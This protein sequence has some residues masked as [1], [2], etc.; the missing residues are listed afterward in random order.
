MLKEYSRSVTH[1]PEYNIWFR[2]L[3]ILFKESCFCI[4]KVRG[5]PFADKWVS[6]STSQYHKRELFFFLEWNPKGFMGKKP[7]LNRH[8]RAWVREN[9][10]ERE[11]ERDMCLDCPN[12]AWV[13]R[14]F[15]THCARFTLLKYSRIHYRGFYAY[16]RNTDQAYLGILDPKSDCIC[17]TASF[18]VA[19]ICGLPSNLFYYFVWLNRRHSQFYSSLTDMSEQMKYFTSFAEFSVLSFI[20]TIFFICSVKMVCD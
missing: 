1:K 7:R 13:I 4:L 14:S 15:L 11:K 17:W 3:G 8:L 12:E 5:S 19:S 9:G 16:A 10:R 20:P 2:T 6:C 18:P